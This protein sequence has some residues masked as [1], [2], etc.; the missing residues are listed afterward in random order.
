MPA[1]TASKFVH[2]FHIFTIKFV[3]FGLVF[4]IGEV[5]IFYGPRSICSVL[6]FCSM[7]IYH[8][9]GHE[10]FVDIKSHKILGRI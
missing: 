3:P 1:M 5:N 4:I 9:N 6:E 7:Q 8:P 10:N 2:I